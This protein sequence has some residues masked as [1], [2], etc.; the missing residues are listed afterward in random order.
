MAV[1]ARAILAAAEAKKAERRPT[2]AVDKED[3][4][5]YDLGHL[6]AFDPSPFDEVAY[7]KDHDAYLRQ[8]ARDNMQLLTNKVFGLL[9]GASSRTVI[10]LPAPTMQLPRE[11]PLPEDKPATRWEKFAKEKGIVKKKRSKMVWDETSQQWAPRY[12]YGRANNPKDAPENWVV[13]AKPGDDGSVDPFEERAKERKSKL[14]KQKR[15][16]E[17][18]RL[19][20]AHAASVGSGGGGG[21]GRGSGGSSLAGRDEKKAYLKRAIASVQSST[22]SVGRFDP[23]LPNEPSRTAGKRKTYETGVGAAA[24]ERDAQ[25][26]A[27]VVSK[28]FPESGRT[29]TKAVDR[30]V[31]AKVSKLQ[32]EAKAQRKVGGG[33][34]KGKV[35]GSA[36]PKSKGAGHKGKAKKK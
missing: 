1:D 19:E 20:A 30:T 28:M 4:L 21:G 29:H 25:R 7:A 35:K 22:A 32:S 16:E 34:S 14:D 8:S 33:I 13:V 31:A 3:D 23:M 11:K 27:A 6:Y 18:N 36:G 12:G 10:P 15:Q 2:I 26:T 9:E 24:T 17:R 5:T